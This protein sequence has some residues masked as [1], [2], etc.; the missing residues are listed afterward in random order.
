MVEVKPQGDVAAT[1]RKEMIEDV[2]PAWVKRCGDRCG[3]VY[4]EV[5]API[6]GIRY[7]AR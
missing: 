3:T 6:T 4:N 5:I 7:G 2:L 1:I